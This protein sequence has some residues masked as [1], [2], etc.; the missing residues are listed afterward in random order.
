MRRRHAA[1]H[2]ATQAWTALCVVFTAVPARRLRGASRC[3]KW[4]GCRESIGGRKARRAHHRTCQDRD[5]RR[6]AQP[7]RSRSDRAAISP[8][9]PH[10]VGIA[11]RR[12]GLGTDGHGRARAY[13]ARGSAIARVA[14]ARTTH[15]WLRHTR[16]LTLKSSR[17]HR[18]LASTN[19][20]ANRGVRSGSQ[21]PQCVRDNP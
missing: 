17:P 20:V 16:R 2:L 8:R 19:G 7:R 11:D 5:K 15:R 9:M 14:A 12:S 18:R 13:A 4:R 6:S 21:G 10:G 1:R 3:Q